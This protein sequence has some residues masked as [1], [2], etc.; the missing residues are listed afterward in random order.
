MTVRQMV[1]AQMTQQSGIGQHTAAEIEEAHQRGHKQ[2]GHIE[3]MCLAC[4]GAHKDDPVE[5]EDSAVQKVKDLALTSAKDSYGWN[6]TP[7]LNDFIKSYV[8]TVGQVDK[9]LATSRALT[10]V[11]FDEVDRIGWYIHSK[12]P[13]WTN[14][15]QHFDLSILDDYK[16]GIDVKG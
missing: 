16:Q 9:R 14:W 1:V 3:G 12:D 6:S 2:A 11:W 5:L 15:G 8:Q 10:E 13:N 7:Y 4:Y